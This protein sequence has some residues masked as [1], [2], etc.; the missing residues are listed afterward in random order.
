[1]S[2]VR[3]RNKTITFPNTEF[4]YYCGM[5]NDRRCGSTGCNLWCK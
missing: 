2:V 4:L 5:Y 3:K 1:M